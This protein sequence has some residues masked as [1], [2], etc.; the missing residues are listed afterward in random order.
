MT[1]EDVGRGP[2]LFLSVSLC[3]S[4][5]VFRAAAL[6]V[7][8]DSSG[9]FLLGSVHLWSELSA[10]VLARVLNIL[11]DVCDRVLCTPGWP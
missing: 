10:S 7:Q 4:C 9:L 8:S 5:R 6:Y 11:N 3:S 2:V 1:M